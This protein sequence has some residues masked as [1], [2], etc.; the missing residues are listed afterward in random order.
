M[1]SPRFSDTFVEDLKAC[2]ALQDD[3]SFLAPTIKP[4]IHTVFAR[5]SWKPEDMPSSRWDAILPAIHL[6]SHLLDKMPQI[7]SM[8]TKLVWGV[9]GTSRRASETRKYLAD[10]P[11]SDLQ[12]SQLYEDAKE[13][14]NDVGQYVRFFPNRQ[15]AGQGHVMTSTCVCSPTHDDVKGR[16]VYRDFINP[17]TISEEPPEV[18]TLEDREGPRTAFRSYWNTTPI[19]AIDFHAKVWAG[20]ESLDKVEF[21]NQSGLGSHRQR[22]QFTLAIAL[23]HE[24]VHA[25]FKY[26][27]MKKGVAGQEREIFFAL[28]DIHTEFGVAWEERVFRKRFNTIAMLPANLQYLLTNSI[29][30]SVSSPNQPVPGYFPGAPCFYQNSTADWDLVPMKYISEWFQE[31]TWERIGRGKSRD[32]LPSNFAVGLRGKMCSMIRLRKTG[33]WSRG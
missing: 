16:A 33:L 4:L 10:P 28:D 27:H 20:F 24:I 7:E 25:A 26:S 14:L 6:A 2:G 19:I 12:I 15:V 18:P 30:L 29:P 17:P 13:V 31:E 8:W 22:L 9:I 3:D 5:E 32:Y 1:S 23:V 11:T 21:A